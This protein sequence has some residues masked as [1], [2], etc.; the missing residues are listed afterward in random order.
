M[1]GW[2]LPRL[3][4]CP[5]AQAWGA[6]R[7]LGA[8][9]DHRNSR[10]VTCVGLSLSQSGPCLGGEL[11]GAGAPGLGAMGRSRGR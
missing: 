6:S 10:A 8:L 1:G 11:L 2:A 9:P 7:L 5:R 4:P 3:H